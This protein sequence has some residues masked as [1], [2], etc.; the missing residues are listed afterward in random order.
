MIYDCFHYNGEIDLLELRLNHHSSFVDFFVIT[1]CP[2]TYSGVPK[3]LYFEEIKDTELFSKF[4]DKIIHNVFAKPPMAGQ[5][6]WAYEIV[7]RNSLLQILPM[8]EDDDVVLY[9]DCD[10]ILRDSG[11]I[12]AVM[13]YNGIVSFDM[14]LC[15]YYLNCVIAPGSDYQP[16][17]SMDECFRSRW[18]MGKACRKKHL[19]MF[20]ENLYAIREYMINTPRKMLSVMDSGWHFSNLGDGKSIYNKMSSLSHS[21]ELMWKY[22]ISPEK[23]ECRRKILMDPLGRNVSFVKTELDVP[24]YVIENM[25]KFEKYV[26]K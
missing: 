26:L 12:E 2:F 16:D 8:L 9:L 10:E 4:K 3:P 14:K 20:S 25:E 22:D 18:H 23:I 15:W 5:K 6:N 1:E 17:Y 21:I 11:S 13:R 19:L 7:Q 24:K